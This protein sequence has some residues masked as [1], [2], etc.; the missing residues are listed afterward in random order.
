MKYVLLIALLTCLTSCKEQVESV[1]TNPGASHCKGEYTVTDN[2]GLV[3]NRYEESWNSGMNAC[4][5]E[6]KPLTQWEIS[7]NTRFDH[8]VRC[9]PQVDLPTLR[10]RSSSNFY[11][12]KND[13]IFVELNSASGVGRR[14]I[15]GELPD[16]SMSFNRQIFCYYLRTDVETEVASTPTDYKKMM[17]W[18]LELG[19]SS[20]AF[21]SMEIRNY[22]DIGGGL[23]QTNLMNDNEGVDYAFCPTLNTPWEFCTELRSGDS[24]FYPNL[25]VAVQNQLRAEATLIRSEDL[26]MM[27][28]KT[29]FDQAWDQ[30]IATG[31]EVGTSKHVSKGGKWK[32]LVNSMFDEKPFI[33]REWRDYLRGDRPEMVDLGSTGILPVCF[34]GK[35]EQILADGSRSWIEGEICY[36]GNGYQFTGN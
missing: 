17:L 35:R 29:E 23:F 12:Y 6:N 3:R 21:H 9:T 2:N 7:L 25:S 13:R 4:L 10:L 31:I 15:I 8:D 30:T 20:S 36:L 27:I 19:A 26:Y 5:T 34:N 18:D 22:E 24:M 16:G 28:S 14:L 32:Y 1:S 33:G 11:S